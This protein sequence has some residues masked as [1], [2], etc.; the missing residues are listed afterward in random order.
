[1]RGKDN[2]IVWNGIHHKTN[3]SGGSTNYGYPDTTYLN[4]V[5]I[6][7]ADKGVFPEIDAKKEIEELVHSH[8]KVE[9]TWKSYKLIK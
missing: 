7:L 4:R 1:M 2:C 3:T 6:E 9:T 5:T 8:S